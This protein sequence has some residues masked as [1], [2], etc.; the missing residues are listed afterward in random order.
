MDTTRQHKVASMLQ[1]EL[2]GW[3]QRNARIFS[4]GALITVTK[5][6]ISPDLS[7]ARVYLSLFN[8]DANALLEDINH[9]SRF[10]RGKVGIDVGKQMRVV[11]EFHFYIDDSLDYIENLE[12]LLK[13]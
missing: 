2:S 6:N 5:V 8:C 3:F 13:Q 10:I 12:K 1:R 9:R 7:I 11:P 4:T